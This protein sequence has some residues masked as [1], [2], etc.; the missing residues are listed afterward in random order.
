M[1][2]IL[3]ELL[4]R[5]HTHVHMLTRTQWLRTE[6]TGYTGRRGYICLTKFVT[7]EQPPKC[8]LSS[9]LN[10]CSPF[11][12]PKAIPLVLKHYTQR[13]R[14]T[15]QNELMFQQDKP[16]CVRGMMPSISISHGL[17]LEKP[18]FCRYVV[19]LLILLYFLSW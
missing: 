1:D 7:C 8:E 17:L 18:A 13:L 3:K 4:G 12:R 10:E 11:P 9:K 16:S 6:G 5:E 14:Y 19:G 15:L 2:R